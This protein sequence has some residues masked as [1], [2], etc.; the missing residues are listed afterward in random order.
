MH[1][2]SFLS[3]G[4]FS[5]LSPCRPFK[6]LF[7]L[8]LVVSL[9]SQSKTFS[10]NFCFVSLYTSAKLSFSVFFY[11]NLKIIL[12]VSFFAGHFFTF[13]LS[14]FCLLFVSWKIVSRFFLWLSF[15]VFFYTL[16][17]L[18]KTGSPFFYSLPF[19]YQKRC[20]FFQQIGETSSSFL[21]VFSFFFFLFSCDFFIIL[22]VK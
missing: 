19:L 11:L 21:S 2:F 18:K 1:L 13:C 22:R 7:S 20:W 10:Q 3:L 14:V 8:S 4:V 9:L 16:I 5:L 6:F 12:I 15:L 17:S